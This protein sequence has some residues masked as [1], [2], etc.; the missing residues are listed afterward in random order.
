MTDPFRL[1]GRT[2]LVTGGTKGIGLAIARVFRQRGAEVVICGRTESSGAAVAAE[3]DLVFRR[4]DVTD[5]ADVRALV[6]VCEAE[7]GGIDVLVNNAGPT[8]LLHTRDVDGP[9]GEVEP[10]AWHRL[11]DRT[12]TG[13][14][15][16]THH[17]MDALVRSG[18]GSVVNISSIAAAQAMPGFDVYAA[19]KAGLEAMTRSVAIGYAHLGVRCNA[20]RVGTIAVDHGDNNQQLLPTADTAPDAWRRAEPPPAG[21]AEDVA[22][23]ALFLAAPAGAYVTGVVLPVDGGLG[24]RSLMPWQ[25]PRPQRK[26][27]V[28]G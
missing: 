19:G 21:T 22:N 5:D 15:L 24:A 9:I 27:P 13:S 7:H 12:L 20:I 8:D 28:A 4:A 18:A 25:T 10:A 3:H 2:A 11:L 6:A 1:D 14:Y 26:D 16:V 17:A 23:A